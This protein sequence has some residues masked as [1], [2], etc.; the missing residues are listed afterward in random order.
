MRVK[1]WRRDGT[2]VY[3]DE[4]RLIGTRYRLDTQ[5]RAAIDYWLGQAKK[6]WL[7]LANRQSQAHLAVG[8]KRF[9]DKA[10]PAGIMK[11]I[12]ERSVSNEEMGMFWRDTE[13]SSSLRSAASPRPMCI[14]SLPS[15]IRSACSGPWIS[16]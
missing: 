12:K 16:T 2:I 11:S 6:Y 4:T 10:T 9:G 13:L 8:L 15:G 3:S 7:Q 1:I 5:H 14:G